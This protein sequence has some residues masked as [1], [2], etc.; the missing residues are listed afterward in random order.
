MTV[1]NVIK[2]IEDK[3]KNF[4]PKNYDGFLAVQITLTDIEGGVLYVEI[5]DHALNIQPYSYNDRQAELM[6]S[7]DNFA[8]LIDKKL[9]A[10]L[11]FGTG[12]LKISGN[13]G[14]AIELAGL[15]K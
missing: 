10:A 9:D 6:I 12:K 5:K 15:F 2:K 13:P 14:K 3:T 7:S 4:D 11:A 1:E 8:K